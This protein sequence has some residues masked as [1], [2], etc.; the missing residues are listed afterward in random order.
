MDAKF[1]PASS[2]AK[3]K[4]V[5]EFCK[6]K[7]GKR[8]IQRILVANNGMAATKSML[9][10]RQWAYMELGDEKAIE[11]V[12]MATPEDLKANAEQFLTRR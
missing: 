12:A 8:P 6:S 4:V 3:R 9:S 5:E 1:V 10:M 2:K 7:G 11:F